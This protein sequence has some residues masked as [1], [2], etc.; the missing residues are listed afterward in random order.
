[1]TL[2]A[3]GAGVLATSAAATALALRLARHD[4]AGAAHALSGLEAL[5]A[6]PRTSD[7]ET[8]R[9]A[10]GTPIVRRTTARDGRGRPS[11]LEASVTWLGHAH[12]L[13]TEALP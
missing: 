4:A 13:A 6:G 10:D 7:L 9:D 12:D 1:M 5:R 3:F 8:W 2:V 11:R